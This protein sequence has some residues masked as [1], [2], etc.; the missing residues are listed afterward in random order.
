MNTK[1]IRIR[2]SAVE[3]DGKNYTVLG[4]VTLTIPKEFVVKTVE[5]EFYEKSYHKQRK[6]KWTSIYLEPEFFR[7]PDISKK[8]HNLKKRNKI[9]VYGRKAYGVNW[10]YVINIVCGRPMNVCFYCDEKLI[11]GVNNTRDHVIPRSIVEAYG[12]YEIP[13][14][15]VPCCREC[16]EEKADL[17]PYIF[18]EKVKLKIRYSRRKN[19]WRRVLKVLNKILIEKEDPFK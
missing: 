14:N 1:R 19:K 12:L 15:T 8:I 16:N 6:S 17:H 13:D 2:S 7:R 5:Q 3:F 18:R 9:F 11:K 4:N 10:D